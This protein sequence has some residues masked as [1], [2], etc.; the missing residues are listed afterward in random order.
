MSHLVTVTG[1]ADTDSLG[2]ILPHEHLVTDLRAPDAPGFGDA[3]VAEVVAVM[4]PRLEEARS[5]G[6]TA[7]FECTPLGVGRNVPALVALARASGMSIVAAA[8][9]YRDDRVPASVRSLND[10]EMDD[11]LRRELTVGLGGTDVRGGFIKLAVSDSGITSL[12]ERLIRSAGRVGGELGV[13]VA[14]HTS[15]G[16]MAVRELDLLTGEGFPAERYVWVHTQAEPDSGYH[17][18]VGQRGGYLEY[19]GLRSSADFDAYV[20]WVRQASDCG[21]QDRVLLSQDAGWYRPGEPRGGKQA[22]FDF[23]PRAFVPRL[24]EAG[25][26][27]ADVTLFTSDNPKRAFA[28]E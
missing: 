20:G 2:M 22:P 1:T 6:I 13:A 17:R 4:A 9:T 18:E 8:G 7:L 15:A 10:A 26:P 5:A 25:F 14:I 21:L 16:A 19:D 28:R 24:R 3:A 27:A 11:W 23:L 12:E